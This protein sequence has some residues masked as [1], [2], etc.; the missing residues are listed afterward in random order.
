M[1]AAIISASIAITAIFTSITIISISAPP[2]IPAHKDSPTYYVK[3]GMDT[4]EFNKVPI[5]RFNGWIYS[6]G[7][8]L[9]VNNSF[10]V[11]TPES[12]IKLFDQ[13]IVQFD[14]LFPSKPREFVINGANVGEC[15]NNQNPRCR[16]LQ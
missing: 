3:Q 8:V 15:S 2:Y 16:K 11:A 5:K 6:E 10:A 4:L 14:K 12:C 7:C 13:T 1:K 9:K